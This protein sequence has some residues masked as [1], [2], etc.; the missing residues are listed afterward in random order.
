M[1]TMATA[2]NIATYVQSSCCFSRCCD[3]CYQPAV[4]HVGGVKVHS[5]L[6]SQILALQHSSCIQAL[7]HSDTSNMQEFVLNMQSCVSLLPAL[8]LTTRTCNGWIRT[9]HLVCKRDRIVE[10]CWAAGKP[11]TLPCARRRCKQL[12][13]GRTSRHPCFLV[14]NL[15]SC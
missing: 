15:S 12:V 1:M 2:L 4:F 10:F 14:C 9:L 6:H 7:Q 3:R 8:I 5:E 11:R 13:L